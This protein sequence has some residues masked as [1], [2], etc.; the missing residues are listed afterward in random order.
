VQPAAAGLNAITMPSANAEPSLQL[1][2]AEQ[3]S[4]FEQA[5]GAAK[6][7]QW[8]WVSLVLALMWLGTGVAW[9]R[10][11][12]R[13]L[14]T[15]PVK[16]TADKKPD[17][18]RSGSEFKALKRACSDNDP[19]AAR[20][21][22]LAWAATVWPETPVTGL[23]ELSRRLDD[24]KLVEALRQLDRAC[25]TGSAWQGEMLAQSLPKAAAQET[26]SA[27]KHTLPELYN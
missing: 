25:Y 14:L 21:H 17:T 3:K 4:P 20:L 5:A 16:N 7:Q 23:N 13:V 26:S 10:A 1:N 15:L 12:Q 6:N 8:M 24:E 22:L 2:Q 19:H 27:K 9:W 18:I 11:R